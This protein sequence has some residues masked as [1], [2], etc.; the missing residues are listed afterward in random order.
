ME[1][2]KN[3]TNFIIPA[4]FFGS[5]IIVNEKI[6]VSDKEISKVKEQNNSYQ[7]VPSPQDKPKV[8]PIKAPV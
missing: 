3:D 7:K 1:K 6:D 4:K 2:K 5:T 8:E